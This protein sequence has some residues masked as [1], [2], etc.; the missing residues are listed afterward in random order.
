MISD[1]RKSTINNKN[2]QKLQEQ[3][4]RVCGEDIT[5]KNGKEIPNYNAPGRRSITRPRKKTV[6][7]KYRKPNDIST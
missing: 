2:K 5:S 4:E 3:V 1:T 6:R 7:K